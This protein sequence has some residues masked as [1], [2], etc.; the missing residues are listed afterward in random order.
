M[1]RWLAGLIVMAILIAV[2]IAL[3]LI[4]KERRDKARV[5][6]NQQA[7]L[8]YSRAF[9]P[10]ISRKQLEDSLRESG[11]KFSEVCCYQERSVFAVQ[12]KVGE[13]DMPWYCSEWPDYVVFE[14]AGTQPANPLPR[15]SDA[16]ELKTIH[17]AS[18]GEGCL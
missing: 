16:D 3:R 4:R 2:V 11:V 15:P 1:K 5:S 18:G 7:L 6:G 12:V 13:E 8:A 10:E 14:F 17:L 9:K